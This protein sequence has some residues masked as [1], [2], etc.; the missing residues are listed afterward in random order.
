MSEDQ[1]GRRI[2][3]DSKGEEI[4]ENSESVIIDLDEEDDDEDEED[5]EDE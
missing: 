4:D 2:V 5:S 3:V 1:R